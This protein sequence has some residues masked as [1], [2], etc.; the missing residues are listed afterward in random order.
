MAMVMIKSRT[1]TKNELQAGIDGKKVEV[2]Q[3][4]AAMKAMLEKEASKDETK[5][6][7]KAKKKN[8]DGPKILAEFKGLYDKY[9]AMAKE[10]GYPWAPKK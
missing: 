3:P 6:L 1:D 4:T 7:A 9:E 8:L 5:W 2:L 10:N